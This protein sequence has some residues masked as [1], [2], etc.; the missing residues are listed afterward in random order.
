MSSADTALLLPVENFRAICEGGQK[1]LVSG[2]RLS[3]ENCI[4]H[5]IIPGF[6]LQSG[7]FTVG[8]GTGGESI[9]GYRFRDESFQ[10]KH[11]GVGVVSMANKGANSNSSQFF[12]CVAPAPWLDGRHVVFGQVLHGLPALRKIESRGNA[13]GAVS[14]T[15]RI[16]KCGVLPK[17]HESLAVQEDKGEVL[18][19]TGR[20]AARIMK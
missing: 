7:D 9:F 1:S 10:L 4:F 20:N 13:K 18:D 8:D 2:K 5:R 19:E 17:L 16:V 6:M 14:G 15:V 12:L 3:Y 11:T